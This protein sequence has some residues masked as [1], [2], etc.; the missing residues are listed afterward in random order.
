MEC[1]CLEVVTSLG[2]DPPTAFLGELRY[3]FVKTYLSKMATAIIE[4]PKRFDDCP[5][6]A[7]FG[8]WQGMLRT[9]G[10][11]LVARCENVSIRHVALP[12]SVLLDN[13]KYGGVE[14]I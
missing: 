4:L 12:C 9:D 7:G 13:G 8:T 1:F 6:C 2:K 14:T 5:G 3:A 11:L 10:R